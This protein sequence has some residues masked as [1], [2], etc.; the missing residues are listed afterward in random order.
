MIL[1][2]MD[3]EEGQWKLITQNVVS[4]FYVPDGGLEMSLIYNSGEELASDVRVTFGDTH[5]VEG[6]FTKQVLP[7]VILHFSLT[8]EDQPVRT[9]AKVKVNLTYVEVNPL[10][11]VN[12]VTGEDDE[13]GVEKPVTVSTLEDGRKEA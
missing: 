7:S 1:F 10:V 4:V 12:I 3:S 9:K 8:V 6:S 11:N 5:P 13:M 2:E